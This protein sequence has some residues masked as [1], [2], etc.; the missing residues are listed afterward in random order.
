MTI[1]KWALSAIIAF[2]AVSMSALASTPE[3]YG[4]LPSIDEAEVSPDGSMVA[5]LET[6]GGTTRVGFYDL[7]TG[8]SNAVSV[9]KLKARDIKW[10]G[11]KFVLLLVSNTDRVETTAGM[12]TWEVW[13]Y[14]SISS[15]GKN[16]RYL[17]SGDTVFASTTT[18][19]DLLHT[20]PDEPDYALFANLNNTTTRAVGVSN[21]RSNDDLFVR[22]WSVYK[23]DL[24]NGKEKKIVT[25]SEETSDF[26]VNAAGEPIIRIDRD[27]SG[28]DWVVQRIESRRKVSEIVRI[29]ATSTGGSR[30]GFSALSDDEKYLYAFGYNNANTLGVHGLNLETGTIDKTFYRNDRYDVDG[31][32]ID[33]ALA[34]VIGARYTD[35]F[36]KTIYFDD[37]FQALHNA[38]AKALKNDNISVTSMSQDKTM[39]VVKVTYA[40]KPTSFYLYDKKAGQLSSLGAAYPEI[41]DGAPVNRTPYQYTA[42]D[43][44]PIRGYLTTPKGKSGPLPA[45]ILPHG[46]PEARDSQNFDWWASFYAARGYA[47]YRPNFRGSTG[48]GW[49]FRAMGYGEWGRR[50]Q[51]DITEGVTALI[52]DGVIDESR[53]C[54]VGASY[55]G[56]AALAGASLT[57]DLYQCAVSVNGVSDLVSMLGAEARESQYS[58]DYWER[59]IGSRFREKDEIAAVS[60]AQQ[61]RAIKAPVMIMHGVNDTVVPIAQSIRMRDALASARK[62]HE[63]IEL[64]D[65]DHW[66]SNEATRIEML[67][68]SIRFIDTHIGK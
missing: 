11:N 37:D 27:E 46:G 44:V 13:R 18:S 58:V 22:G 7:A 59:R 47:V 30:L 55:G 12:Q 17:F 48:Y 2:C 67:R 57:P 66:L 62:P 68:E 1:G 45:I 35:D 26:I 32:V 53:L 9:G 31:L 29:P 15:D 65:E 14:I 6:V 51:D 36:P 56:Y 52:K 42:S 23:V 5:L 4:R 8:A 33:P 21:I 54:I 34:R 64:A 28:K 40:N 39:A 10:A 43:G 20:L 60:P 49:N 19:G 38:L 16:I 25:G 41:A 61:V 63:Y 50:M 24:R 3:I